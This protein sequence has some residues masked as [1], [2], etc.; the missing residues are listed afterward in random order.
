MGTQ[1]CTLFTKFVRFL[2][3]HGITRGI[4]TKLKYLW[5][6][7]LIL[8]IP[9]RFCQDPSIHVDVTG[10]NLTQCIGDSRKSRESVYYSGRVTI[11]RI[12]RIGRYLKKES[13]TNRK[14]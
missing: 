14:D 5:E 10:H 11:Y 13:V 1:F 6:G 12:G 3:S 4:N 8:Y 7:Y 9:L 2:F